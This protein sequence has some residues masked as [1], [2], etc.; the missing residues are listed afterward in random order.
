MN[1]SASNTP[2]AA[3]ADTRG[4]DIGVG[5]AGVVDTSIGDAKGDARTVYGRLPPEV[6]QHIVRQSY[7]KFRHCYEEGLRRNRNLEGMVSTR[8]II[9]RDGDKLVFRTK[10]GRPANALD[11]I[12]KDVFMGG[13]DEK[14]LLVFRRDDSG[15]V[16]ELIERRK[17][18]DLRLKRD[19]AAK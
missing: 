12:A 8:F 19:A 14:N 4:L 5:D 6:I 17:F 13:D 1:A 11:P 18:N 16:T 7:G 9:E 15:R 10:A 2:S 3:E